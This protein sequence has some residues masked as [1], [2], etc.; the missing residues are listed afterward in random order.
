MS[1][2]GGGEGGGLE[3]GRKPESN[4]LRWVDADGAGSRG[5]A[6]ILPRLCMHIIDASISRG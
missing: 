1:A 4:P 3:L 6:V 2:D 5:R